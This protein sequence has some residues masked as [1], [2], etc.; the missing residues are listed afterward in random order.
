MALTPHI[1]RLRAELRA[2]QRQKAA[3][4]KARLKA[5]ARRPACPYCSS[6]STYHPTSEDFYQGRDFGPVWAC[7]PCGAYV[8]CHKQGASKQTPGDRPLGTLANAETRDLRKQA[9]ALFD[10][11]WRRKMAHTG[12]DQGEARGAGYR[13]L[14]KQLGVEPKDCH[15]GHMQAE[16]LRQVIDICRPFVEA[17]QIRA[18]QARQERT[19]EGERWG[20][21]GD[22]TDR[23]SSDRQ[24][25]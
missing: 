24:A 21:D 9:H 10:E 14:A 11:L 17:P 19:A 15:I 16:L 18:I 12:C 20:F 4:E 5:E 8:G 1:K 6:P 7:V 22:E 2:A 23:P 25:S 13:W 3:E